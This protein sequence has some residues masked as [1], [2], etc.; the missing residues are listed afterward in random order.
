MVGILLQH[1]DMNARMVLLQVL[2]PLLGRL[3][4]SPNKALA[5]EAADELASRTREMAKLKREAANT[6]QASHTQAHA[7]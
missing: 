3:A 4:E 6:P 1:G 5:A 2:I 7:A